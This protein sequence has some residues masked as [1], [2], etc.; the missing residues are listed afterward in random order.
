ENKFQSGLGAARRVDG[1]RRNAPFHFVF[2]GCGLRAAQPR[3]YI[4][5]VCFSA[6][7][8]TR[9]KGFFQGFSYNIKS[10]IKRVSLG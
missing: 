3:V 5:A 1:A 8:G 10:R 6:A 9:K 7:A 4:F 2:A